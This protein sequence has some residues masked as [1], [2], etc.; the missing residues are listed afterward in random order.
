MVHK[1]LEQKDASWRC[2]VHPPMTAAEVAAAQSHVIQANM[3]AS[4]TKAALLSLEVAESSNGSLEEE[5]SLSI[6]AHLWR[7]EMLMGVVEVDKQGLVAKAG[8]C[9]LH[10]PGPLLGVSSSAL[11]H[12][13]LSRWL[14]VPGSYE[15]LLMDPRKKGALKRNVADV[16]VGPLR[17]ACGV[18]NDGGQVHV[19][20]QAVVR[21]G[22]GS[23]RLVVKL[24]IE[25]AAKGDPHFARRLLGLLAEEPDK[26][27]A[28][29]RLEQGQELEDEVPSSKPVKARGGVKFGAAEAAAAEEVQDDAGA[30]ERRGSDAD[31]GPVRGKRGKSDRLMEWVRQASGLVST[32]RQEAAVG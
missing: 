20:V 32:E 19:N 10:Q 3:L 26:A 13:P 1:V 23:D 14:D 18:H 4:R 5:A 29:T 12:T 9:A 24:G 8:C 27:A 30:D 2:G 31:E 17:H 16:K 22:G 28:G 25:K 15:G 7:S 11:L 21:E 6:T